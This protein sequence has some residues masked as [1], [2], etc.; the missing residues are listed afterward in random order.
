MVAWSIVAACEVPYT[1]TY[2]K[3]TK[4]IQLHL[5]CA[6]HLNGTGYVDTF[7]SQIHSEGSYQMQ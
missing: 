3:Y 7:T 4:S 5:L 6:S 1:I 2:I